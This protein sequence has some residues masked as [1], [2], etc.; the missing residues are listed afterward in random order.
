ML[1]YPMVHSILLY[2]QKKIKIFEVNFWTEPA[3]ILKP[4]FG[5]FCKNVVY[6][7]LGSEKAYPLTL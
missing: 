6:R 3:R 7:I 4:G 1:L 2:P 5:R